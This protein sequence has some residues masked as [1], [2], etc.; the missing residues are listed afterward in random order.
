MKR[1]IQKLRRPKDGRKIMGV[2]AGLARFVGIE[3][4][5]MRLIWAMICMFPPI[6]T[7][8]AVALYLILAYIIPEEKD[9]IDV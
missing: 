9:Y 2:C 4:V 8:T 1:K 7:I 5:Y 3:P 6:S